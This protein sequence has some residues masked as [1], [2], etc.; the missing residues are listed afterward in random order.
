MSGDNLDPHKKGSE[1]LDQSDVGDRQEHETNVRGH[2][3]HQFGESGH[4]RFNDADLSNFHPQ[5]VGF[6]PVSLTDERRVQ[7]AD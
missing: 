2:C 5:A 1:E 7:G 4:V 3:K 6:L